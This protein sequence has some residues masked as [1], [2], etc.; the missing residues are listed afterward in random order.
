M[1]GC[2]EN[3]QELQFSIDGVAQT[4]GKTMRVINY[5]IYQGMTRDKA[6]NYDNFVE[7]VKSYDPDVLTLQETNDFT[8]SSLKALAE[9][10]G[11]H[12]VAI[13]SGKNFKIPNADFTN[14]Y[15][16][17]QIVWDV[18]T[19]A[20]TSKY[21]IEIREKFNSEEVHHGAIFATIEGQN[22]FCLHLSPNS[23][24]KTKEAAEA[25]RVKE[26]NHYLDNTFRKYPDETRWLMMG[27][28]NSYS[29]LDSTYY[30]QN[31]KWN[32]PSWRFEPNRLIM[33]AGY[34]DALWHLHPYFQ[35]TTTDENPLRF[36][37]IY[38]TRS[39][40]NNLTRSRVIYD[41]FTRKY[42][43]HYPVMVEFRYYNNEK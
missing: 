1:P 26:T 30:S 12:Y 10:Y 18:Y 31:Y 21:P 23:S 11:H 39:I 36:D 27:D 4:G 6:N 38:T 40:S 16:P 41:E 2:K 24:W 28:L 25:F 5:N 33:N 34:E 37:Y 13:I 32:F 9:R 19:P 20:I 42:S 7:W 14:G 8:E 3:E 29:P 43:D 15:T 22:F 35:Y 17:G